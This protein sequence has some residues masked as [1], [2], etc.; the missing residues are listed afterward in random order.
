MIAQSG[1][2]LIPSSLPAIVI[3]DFI[4]SRAA[5]AKEIRQKYLKLVIL[6]R[7]Q[8]LCTCLLLKGRLLLLVFLAVKS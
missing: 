2:I 5:E 6:L 4:N 8:V 1:Q 3:V 7:L